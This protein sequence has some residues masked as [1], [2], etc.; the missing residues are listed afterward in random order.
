MIRKVAVIMGSDSDFPV[1]SPAI[2]RLKLSC[3]IDE[4]AGLNVSRAALPNRCGMMVKIMEQLC[5]LMRPQKF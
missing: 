3:R 1:V 2:R 5:V 4:L